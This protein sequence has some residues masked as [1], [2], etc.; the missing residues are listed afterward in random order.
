MLLNEKS[1]LIFND[2]IA[3]KFSWRSYQ[4]VFL[5]NFE[6][7][8]VDNHLHVI[9]PPG[10][11]KTIL[12]LEMLRRINKKTLVLTPTLTIKHQWEEK[13]KTFFDVQNKF[14]NISHNLKQLKDLNF[15]TYQGVFALHKDFKT[16]EDFVN[17]F[18]NS[19]I[20]VLVL[21]EA[22]HLKQE[23]WKVLF[24]LKQSAN[25]VIVA[26]T[27]TPPIDSS[28]I[29][30][31]RY[32]SLCGEVDEEISIPDLVKE[33]ALCPHQDFIYFSKPKDA[34]IEYIVTFRKRIATFIQFLK[35]D[36][37]FIHFLKTHAFY[38]FPQQNIEAIY[39]DP[40]YYSSILIFLNDCGEPIS[41][42]KLQ[43]LGFEKNET[44]E[45]PVLDINWIT[46]LLQKILFEYRVSLEYFED[47]LNLIEKNL[48]KIGG[49]YNKKV[50]LLANQT[51]FKKITNSTNKLQSIVSIVK[52]E[53]EQ[54]KEKL[55]LVI[56]T[57][58]IR[59]EFLGLNENYTKQINKIGV[60]PIF[61]Y[62]KK[63]I[64]NTSSIAVLSG[65]IIILNK[66]CLNKLSEYLA[67]NQFSIKSID[68]SNNFIELVV[69]ESFRRGSVALITHL[70]EIGDIKILIGTKSLLGEGWDAPSINSL[71]LAS[72]IGSFVSSNQMRGRAIRVKQANKTGHIWHLASIDITHENGGEDISKLAQRFEAFTGLS[73]LGNSI[74]NGIKRL[75]I[76]LN[77][78][79]KDL[80]ELNKKTFNKAKNRTDLI[81]DWDTAIANGY[82]LKKIV[83]VDF[84]T[85]QAFKEEKKVNYTKLSKNVF[86]ELGLGFLYFTFEY[87]TNN[88]VNLLRGNFI[89][90]LK[91]FII[92]LFIVFLPK[93]FKAIRRYY[94]LGNVDK[95]IYKIGKAVLQTMLHSNLIK[96]NF[97]T[98]QI[99]IVKDQKGAISCSLIGA[100]YFENSLF[101]TSLN[102]ILQPIKNP[103]Y[104]ILRKNWMKDKIGIYN[105]HS[106]PNIFDSN[107]KSATLFYKNWKKYVGKSELLFSRSLEGRKLLLKAKIQNLKYISE[108]DKN[109][110]KTEEL[111]K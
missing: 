59:K 2:S 44:I 81:K 3:F 65:S 74:K 66:N 50:N 34:E 78:Y 20:Q 30:L 103:R 5:D 101:V 64:E 25:L 29:E 86:I 87:I 53:E 60:I 104:I 94:I 75:N 4:K 102:E 82:S 54:L 109:T 23:W 55:R 47:S 62:L 1:N 91:Y 97:N 70:F 27:A 48:K 68:N 88:L 93:T 12:G 77:F 99:E 61:H 63:Y 40:S 96:T 73:I 19:G 26:L 84:L 46:I 90:V 21:D 89:F 49:I 92:S 76:P 10:A 80:D 56:L 57:D 37:K 58:F 31:S 18:K 39:N 71:I 45:F 38:E 72:N 43:F 14:T 105:M 79:N 52:F 15:N 107:K 85:T 35:E 83:K 22:H 32:F 11:G 108:N 41:Q 24:E 110:S 51:I 13:F 9:A 42:G 98:I 8:F 69:N 67:P 17:Y 111:W 6:T 95:L 33:R 106:V 100:S 16:S 36:E 28:P 7:H